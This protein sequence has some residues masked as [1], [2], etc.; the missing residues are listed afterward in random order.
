[1]KPKLF[2]LLAVSL[3]AT[4]AWAQ[5]NVSTDQEL[6]AA[7]QND[8]VDI[9]L[10]AD[11]DLSNSTLSIESNRTVT[12]NLDGHTLNRG[13]KSSAWHTGGQVRQQSRK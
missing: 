7:L 3:C 12:I 1:M 13:L 8:N 9:I 2:T 6:R 11:I 4:A 10:C 5:T